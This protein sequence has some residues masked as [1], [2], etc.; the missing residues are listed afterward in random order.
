MTHFLTENTWEELRQIIKQY[1]ENTSCARPELMSGFITDTEIY[2]DNFMFDDDDDISLFTKGVSWHD[3]LFDELDM[4]DTIYKITINHTCFHMNFP[5]NL[6]RFTQLQYL[7]VDLRFC[8]NDPE[9]LLLPSTIR[10]LVLLNY[11]KVDLSNLVDLEYLVI[12]RENVPTCALALPKLKTLLIS[13]VDRY[14]E[15]LSE[16]WQERIKKDN[17]YYDVIENFRI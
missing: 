5:K 3:L 9:G 12:E 4:Y 17:I 13:I 11:G 7:A 2:L 14:P 6:N 15:R 1:R 16:D 8:V 10:H